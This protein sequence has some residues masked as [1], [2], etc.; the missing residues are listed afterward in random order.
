[1]EYI[2]SLMIIQDVLKATQMKCVTRTARAAAFTLIELP[3]VIGIVTVL[4]S[5]FLPAVSKVRERARQVKCMSNL[6]SLGHALTMYTQETGYYP[7]GGFL[8]GYGD[9]V[10]VWP[11]RLRMYMSGNRDVFLCPSR[12]Q[13]FVWNADMQTKFHADAYC[14]KY[15]YE[16]GE[17]TLSY[18]SFFSYGYNMIGDRGAGSEPRDGLGL[19]VD[20]PLAPTYHE[21]RTSTVTSPSEMIA[22]ADSRGNGDQD[23]LVGLSWQSANPGPIHSGGANVLLCDG[24]VQWYPHDDLMLPLGDRD[25]RYDQIRQMWSNRPIIK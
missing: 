3:V 17:P 11:T 12:D 22:I 4:L 13:R 14:T 2:L 23:I 6:A 21:L 5:I 10:A 19:F 7:G 1:M 15:G 16:L 8:V 24:H 25:P 9:I 18:D 20:S